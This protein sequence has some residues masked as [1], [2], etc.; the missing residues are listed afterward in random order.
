MKI[1]IATFALALTTTAAQAQGTTQQDVDKKLYDFV[2]STFLKKAPV[3]DMSKVIDGSQMNNKEQVTNA[4]DAIRGRV[5]GLQVERNGANAL[6]AV[7]LR[8]TSSLAGGNN[9]LIIVDGVMGDLTLLQSIYPTDIESFTIMKDASETSQYGSRGAA[10]VIKITTIKGSTGKMKV[11]YN[12]LFGVSSVYKTLDMLDASG[13]RSLASQ[14]GVDILDKGSSTDFDKEIT[15]NAFTQQHHLAFH[16]GSE[17]SNYR[18]SI[19]YIDEQ[20]II[21]D[22]GNSTFMANMNASQAMFDGLLH[23]DLGMFGSTADQEKEADVQKLM[24]SAA[25]WNPTFTNGKNASGS[26]DGYSS[27]SQTNN[28]LALLGMKNDSESSHLNFHARLQFNVLPQLNV[29]LFGAYSYDRDEQKQYNPT[30]V[31]NKGQAYRGTDKKKMLMG[32]ATITYN[33]T[34]GNHALNIVGMAE[35]QKDTYSGFYTTV[36]NFASDTN[37]YEDL[38]GGALRPWNG[39]GSYYENPRMTSFMGKVGYS[40]LER[41]IVNASVRTDGSSKFGDNHKWGV[42]PSVSGAWV[43][44]KEKFM[45]NITFVNNLKINIGYG[46][47]GNQSSIDSYTT[48]SRVKADGA[49]P[50]GSD[51][52]VTFSKLKNINPDLKWEVSRTFNIGFDAEMLDGRLIASLNYYNTKISD[53]LYPYT[54]SVPPFTYPTLIA[55]LGSMRNRGLELSLGGTPIVTKDVTLTINANVTLQS[56]KLVSLGGEYNGEHLYAPTYEAIGELNG[57]GFHG[58]YNSVTYQI[59]GESLGV[60]Y[61]PKSNGLATG[62]N[63]RKTYSVAD[64]NGEGVDLSEGEDRYIAGQAMPK[65][66]LGSNISLRYKDFDVSVQMNG[67]FGHKIYNGT[68]LAY[69]NVSSFPL[70]NILKEA[71]GENIYDQTVTDYWLENGDY[72]NI[73]YITIGWRVPLP[74]NKIVEAMRLSLTMNNVATFTSYSGL[75]PMINSTNVNS[76]YG[77]DDKRSYPLYHSYVLG[78]SLNF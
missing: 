55:N 51:Y 49:T 66:L 14:L 42:F 11:N 43:I 64:L 22:R 13:Y 7:R 68:S 24:Y 44:S 35:V 56:N 32:N 74:K 48:L 39:T 26:Y 70:Y 63:G 2:D 78:L 28:P 75:T 15:R 38:S 40:L 72:L 3:I 37:G 20:S 58:G 77:I 16:G 8:G 60:F 67:A 4:L 62:S 9:P 36:T 21:R 71:V 57:A 10:G 31:W 59:V 27:A 12:G 33:E 29:T 65:V 46:V 34:F 30:S 41:Y 54:V 47:S 19:G 69:M 23:I 18:V 52:V 53:M 25:T 1:C 73:D 45:R 61:I 76:T 5:A 17:L 6:N 50:T